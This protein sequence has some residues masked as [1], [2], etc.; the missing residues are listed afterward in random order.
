MRGKT[1]VLFSS[2]LLVAPLLCHGENILFFFGFSTYSHRI[3]VWPLVQQLADRGHNVTFYQPISPKIPDPRVHELFPSAF[4]RL[5]PP[6]RKRLEEFDFLG[7]RLKEGRI[8]NQLVSASLPKLG[9]EY[10][11]D[12]LRSPEIMEWVE[13]SSFDL[14]ILD[15][16]CANE[17]GLGLGAKFGA[18]VILYSSGGGEPSWPDSFGFPVESSWLTNQYFPFRTPMSL[19]ERALN[20]LLPVLV[21]LQREWFYYPA[22][23]TL[24]R[25][26]LGMPDMPP[27]AQLEKSSHLALINTHFSEGEPNSIPPF[28]IPIGGMHIQSKQEMGIPKVRF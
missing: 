17:C 27:L 4:K 11:E 12:F 26:E 23:E 16:L 8:G 9:I 24:L 2:V 6:G 18:K 15:S 5:P 7:I 10:C 19:W 3:A 13:S 28:M 22:L 20:T 14:L 21:H 1:I 25:K